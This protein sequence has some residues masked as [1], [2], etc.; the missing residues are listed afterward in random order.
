[1]RGHLASVNSAVPLPWSIGWGQGDRGT[2]AEVGTPRVG[3]PG[4]HHPGI[5]REFPK[6]EPRFVR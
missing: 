5:V 3:V 1:L 2:E 4:D 6:A